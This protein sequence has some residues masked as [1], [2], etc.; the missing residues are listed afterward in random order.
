MRLDHA[1]VEPKLWPVWIVLGMDVAIAINFL[2]GT[3][4]ANAL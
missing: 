1:C 3:L 2:V 4:L